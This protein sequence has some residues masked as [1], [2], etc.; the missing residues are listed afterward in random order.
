MLK[1]GNLLFVVY[2]L[3]LLDTG[4]FKPHT[5]YFALLTGIIF[6]IVTIRNKGC[7]LIESRTGFIGKLLMIVG[8]LLTVFSGIDR[9]ESVFGFIRLLSILIM[10]LA[11]QQFEQ[12]DKK[13]LLSGIPFMGVLSVAG[14]FFHRYAFFKGWISATGRVNGPFGYANTMALFLLL[15]IIILEHTVRWGRGRRLVQLVLALGVLMTGS[16]TAF[17]IL[18]G[19]LIGRFIKYR[20]K[21]KLI[22]IAFSGMVS[23][24]GGISVAVGKPYAMGRFL[25]LSINASTLQGRL[26]YWEDAVRMLLKHPAGL[27]YMGY[28]YVQQAEQTGV[29]SVR[30]VHNDWLQWMLDYGILAGVGL[31]IYLYSQCRWDKMPL[32]DKELLCVISIYSFFD[33]HMQFFAIILIALLL[34]PGGG[35]IWRCGGS[36][37]KSKIWRNTLVIFAGLSACMCIAAG[38][39]D[40]Y[41]AR[42]EY[43]QAVKWNPLSAQY[44][45]EYL[46]QSKDLK[47][48]EVY[49]DRLL[50]GNKYLYVA[51]LIKSN[52]AAVDGRLNDFIVNRQK[53]LNLRQYKIEEYEDYLEILFGWYKKANERQDWREMSVC[54]MAMQEVPD[55]IAEVRRKTGVR[56]Y[57][58]KD[59]PNLLLDQKYTDLIAGMSES[60]NE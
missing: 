2:F 25:E 31:V 15:G 5:V 20:G 28:F 4:G 30:F 3:I 50:A 39:A 54:R 36:E 46:L 11:A 34:I 58:I 23:L 60:K 48:A 37:K 59:K 40:Y 35:K 38:I 55:M 56:A 7:L 42:R 45:Q 27:G 44:K 24:V 47:S 41:A 32:M 53:V 22:L 13:I 17:V 49:A 6:L 26:L 9:G 51:Y 19:Y 43:R 1:G 10:G 29:Y 21:N 16:R 14:C 8:A 33:F 52:A 57:R 18:C 12:E